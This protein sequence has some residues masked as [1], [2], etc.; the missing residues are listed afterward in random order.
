M[1]NWIIDKNNIFVN[2]QTKNKVYYPED[3]NSI[4]YQIEEKSPWFKQRNELIKTIIIKHKLNGNFLDIG[5][6]NGFQI[7]ALEDLPPIKETFLI[8]PGYEG[9]LN[10]KTRGLKMFFCG[11]F[12]DFDF[13]KHN[14]NLCGLFDVLEHIK[15]DKVFL[16]ELYDKINKDT[17]VII[18]V[19][20]L[21]VLWSED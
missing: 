3:G 12:Q 2:K 11:L 13:K 17:Y 5:G 21:R 1:D 15:D 19:P 14:I 18:N 9:C 8:E 10:A 4:F 20:S 16:N 6:G 7:K